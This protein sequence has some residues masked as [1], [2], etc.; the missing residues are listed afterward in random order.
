MLS[1]SSWFSV[2]AVL[3]GKWQLGGMDLLEVYQRLGNMSMSYEKNFE[4]NNKHLLGVKTTK[5]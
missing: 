1:Q 4:P 5:H 3:L 2:N